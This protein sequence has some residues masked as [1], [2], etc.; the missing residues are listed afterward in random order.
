MPALACLTTSSATATSSKNP[1]VS[2]L[3]TARLSIVLE[4]SSSSLSTILHRIVGSFNH[5]LY[6]ITFRNVLDRAVDMENTKR[7]PLPT[8]TLD[9]SRTRSS[10]SVSK[11]ILA[12]W[13]YRISIAWVLGSWYS[14]HTVLSTIYF[15]QASSNP[16]QCSH[17]DVQ[18]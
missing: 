18:A 1:A 10:F 4:F 11:H 8:P 13:M 3:L 15:I 12:S 7:F 16:T 17:S 2:F 9:T 5:Q 14:D 6:L